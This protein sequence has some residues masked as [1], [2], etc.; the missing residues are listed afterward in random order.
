MYPA[1]KV[2]AAGPYRTSSGDEPAAE[3]SMGPV[4]LSKPTNPKAARVIEVRMIIG[5]TIAYR[6]DMSRKAKNN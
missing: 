5:Q 2:S 4:R 6:K 1:E 3:A